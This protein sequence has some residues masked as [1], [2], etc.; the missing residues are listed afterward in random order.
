MDN[1]ILHSRLLRMKAK[2]HQLELKQQNK[3]M[4]VQCYDIVRSYCYLNYLYYFNR[5]KYDALM[6]LKEFCE[7][8]KKTDLH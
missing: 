7:Q 5:P 4:I 3:P 1:S 8:L 6:R 2:Q